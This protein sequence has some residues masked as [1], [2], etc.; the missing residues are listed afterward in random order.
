MRLSSDT[1]IGTPSLELHQA[2]I[3]TATDL[4]CQGAADARKGVS[5]E[6]KEVPISQLVVK[7]MLRLKRQLR[8]SNLQV[9]SEYELLDPETHAPGVK[10][11]IDIIFQFAH[12][13]GDEEAYL[14]VE[15]KRVSPNH[16]KWSQ[17]YVTD[18]VDR[19]ATGQYAKNHYWG[20]M[21]GYVLHMPLGDLVDKISNRVH[22]MYGHSSKLSPS[23]AHPDSLCMRF[24][25]LP[26]GSTGH[27]I[28]LVHIFVDMS[29][30]N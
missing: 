5:P 24:G 23:S 1:P 16:P 25:D 3:D 7:S 13:F 17:R 21:L 14:A 27:K 11:R 26:Q 6:M 4:I 30:T 2:Q 22:S 19:F 15:C 9:T 10:G 8:L 18:G 28:R 12:Q 20:M 29:P